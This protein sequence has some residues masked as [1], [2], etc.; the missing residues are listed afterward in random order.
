MYL[1]IM[2]VYCFFLNFAGEIYINIIP[3]QCAISK[4]DAINGIIRYIEYFKT[5]I[6]FFTSHVWK[7]LSIEFNNA[8]DSRCWY[9]NVKYNR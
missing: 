4:E 5:S 9:T 3:C 8:W 2:Y 6:S 1:M 7:D